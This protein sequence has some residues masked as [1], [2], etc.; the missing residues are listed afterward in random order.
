MTSLYPL[1]KAVHVH[2]IGLSFAIFFLRGLLM[3]MRSKFTNH[4]ALRY[5]SYVVDTLLLA[6]ALVLTVMIA[7]YPF[8]HAWLTA[9]VLLLLAYIVLGVLALRRAKTRQAQILAF[10]AA[11]LTF[12]MIFAI[13]RAHHWAGPFASLLR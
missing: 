7:Q 5:T 4:A 12:A 13:A 1:I 2:A 6:A 8:V 10:I 3:L 11:C 9:K